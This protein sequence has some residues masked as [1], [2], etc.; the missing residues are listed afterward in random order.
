MY[1]GVPSATPSEVSEDEPLDA[2]IAFATPKSVT[3]A[4]CPVISTLSGL[5]S[6]CTTP[7]ACAYASASTTSR[8]M[9]TASLTGISPSRASFA[10]SDSPSTSGIV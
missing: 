9:R 7:R 4:C 1:A 10:R 6:R 2:L 5:M 3:T 8:R